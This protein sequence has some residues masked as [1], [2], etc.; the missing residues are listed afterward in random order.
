MAVTIPVDVPW[1]KLVRAVGEYRENVEHAT[2][3]L[4]EA[5][6][7]AELVRGLTLIVSL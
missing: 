5:S 2:T 3:P 1:G 7:L 6:S 4:C